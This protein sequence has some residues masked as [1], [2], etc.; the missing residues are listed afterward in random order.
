MRYKYVFVIRRINYISLGH[1]PINV[2]VGL[3][4][5]ASKSQTPEP[6]NHTR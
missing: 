6:S 2:L 5:R 4:A 3:K 1:K